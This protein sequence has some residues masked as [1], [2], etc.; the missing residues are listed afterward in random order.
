[1]SQIYPRAT[2]CYRN[3]R[4]VNGT[5]SRVAYRC[6]AWQ[7]YGRWIVTGVLLFISLACL[8]TYMILSRKRKRA[9]ML[10]MHTQ[11]PLAPNGGYGGYAVPGQQQYGENGHGYGQQQ[12]APPPGAPPGYGQG[13]GHGGANEGYYGQQGGVVPPGNVYSK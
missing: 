12:Y 10:N 9:R 6:S 11:P 8:I 7:R 2:T 13:G 1:M 4:N 3:V 5:R